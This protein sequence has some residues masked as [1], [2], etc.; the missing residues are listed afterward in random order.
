[1][2]RSSNVDDVVGDYKPGSIRRIKLK[3]FLTYSDAVIEPGPRY[4]F[5][6]C[7]DSPPVSP[8]R[9]LDGYL[10]QC[11]SLEF[12]VANVTVYLLSHAFVLRFPLDRFNMVVG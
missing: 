3:N 6:R 5:W 1:M 7:S 10:L 8:H 4:V 2:A 9:K 12:I 11:K